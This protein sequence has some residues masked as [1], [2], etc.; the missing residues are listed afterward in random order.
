MGET[1]V[2]VQWIGGE[3][4]VGVDSTQHAV[5]MSTKKDSIGMKPSDML[6]VAVGAC[7]AVDVVG[8]LQKKR[9]DLRGLDIQVSGEQ[10]AAPPWTFKKIHV[11]YTLRGKALTPA[12]VEQAI[13]LSQEKYCSVAST[14]RG[15]AALS[16]SYQIV[17]E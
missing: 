11:T 6:L 13:D 14:L 17:E 7:S 10:D 16:H 1:T 8:I 5:V 4:F 9:L 12:A 15:A 2:K 3:R